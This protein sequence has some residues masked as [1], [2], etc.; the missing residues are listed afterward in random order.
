MTLVYLDIYDEYLDSETLNI[1]AHKHRYTRNFICESSFKEFENNLYNLIMTNKGDG[2]SIDSVSTKNKHYISIYLL[3][4][5]DSKYSIEYIISYLEQYPEINEDKALCDSSLKADTFIKI[6]YCDDILPELEELLADQNVEITLRS[7]TFECGASSFFSGI[8]IG[9][10]S[11]TLS[12]LIL[13]TI[14]KLANREEYIKYKQCSLDL[15]NL[16][17]NI[18]HFSGENSKNLYIYDFQKSEKDVY[19]VL[20]SRYNEY[21]IKCKPNGE[22]ISFR[23]DSIQKLSK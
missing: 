20:R 15:E 13:A 5:E 17:R 12:G 23:Q 2:L 19:V 9:T 11:G 18:V 10:I 4:D 16:K 1:K 3:T 6:D 22:I 21:R 8:I 14:S 7:N